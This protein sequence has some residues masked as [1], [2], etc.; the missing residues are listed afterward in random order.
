MKK[1]TLA[2]TLALT[3]GTAAT[4]YA[5][6]FASDDP[7][8]PATTTTTTAAASAGSTKIAVLDVSAVMQQSA[9]AKA[10][11]EQLKKEFKPRQDSII[12]LQQQLQKDQEKY[13]RDAAVMSSSDAE[14]LRNKITS[15]QRDLQQKQDNYMQDLRV[16]Q[17]TAMQKVLAQI[18][19][20]VAKVAQ[21]QHYDLVLQKQS[22][23]Y[24]NNNVDI[25]KQVVEQLKK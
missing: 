11:G 21:T 15:E 2:F 13:K 23:A 5:A 19:K 4:A 9:Q 20:V 7:S 17:S 12:S 6:W 1:R 14:S 22:V 18:D 8:A 10:A 3:L 25:T 24:S 16:A